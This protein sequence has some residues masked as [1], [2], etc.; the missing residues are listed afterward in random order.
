MPG[1]QHCHREELFSNPALC[2]FEAIV[3]CTVTP[4][5]C[6]KSL[7]RSFGAPLLAGPLR[8]PWSLHQAEYPQLSACQSLICTSILLSYLLLSFLLSQPLLSAPVTCK[9][10]CEVQICTNMCPVHASMDGFVWYHMKFT[11]I[12]M[13]VPTAQLPQ[14]FVIAP[15][16]CGC[17]GE[18][19]SRA[20]Q[21][22]AFL[23]KSK[24]FLV[25]WANTYW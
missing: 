12:K 16:I 9:Q 3:P 21:E 2:Q 5:S 18:L 4:S 1:P 6:P 13:L 25:C 22:V 11:H 19:P 8:S 17:T 23:A 24:L 7:S 15:F 10:S 20:I 14:I